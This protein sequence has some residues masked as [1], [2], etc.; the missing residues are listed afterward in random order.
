MKKY[1]EPTFEL[2]KFKITDVIC[3]SVQDDELVG[4]ELTFNGSDFLNL[5]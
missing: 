1:I 3:V 5:Y 4:K 2:N